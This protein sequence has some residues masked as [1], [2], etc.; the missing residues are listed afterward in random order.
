[1]LPWLYSPSWRDM[2]SGAIHVVRIRGDGREA[3]A[4]AAPPSGVETRSEWWEILGPVI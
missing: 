2:H 3:E 1:M 4:D